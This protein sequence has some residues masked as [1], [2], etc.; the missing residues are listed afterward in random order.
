VKL[1]DFNTVGG[2]LLSRESRI[3][4]VFWLRLITLLDSLLRDDN[5]RVGNLTT[6]GAD[7]DIVDTLD[8]LRD[9]LE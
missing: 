6:D 8:S 3:I 2:K 7:E 4:S 5:G 9:A 1:I